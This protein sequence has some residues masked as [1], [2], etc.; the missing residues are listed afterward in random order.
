VL[1][2]RDTGVGIAP[3]FI[4]HVFERFRQADSSTTR[5]HGGVGLGLSIVQHLVELHAGTISVSSEGRDRGTAVVVTFPVA[6]A[7]P[8]IVAS[9]SEGATPPAA[10]LDGKRVL[11][12]D[13][14]PGALDLLVEALA[15]AGARV[16]S[17]S[18]ARRALEQLGANGA[19]AIVSDIAMPDEDGYWLM[20]RIRA[21]PGQLGRT[22]AVAL[23]AL[24]RSE[25]RAR[26]MEAGYQLYFTKPVRLGE[27]QAGLAML[28]AENSERGHRDVTV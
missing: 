4:P 20:N 21:L 13:D 25:D 18:S 28:M 3:E 2:V 16:S 5:S 9:P 22:P 8:P 19:D 12:V 26:V 14:D 7:S 27:L 15:G 10:R 6:P 11:V 1:T 17:A 23:T 24:A